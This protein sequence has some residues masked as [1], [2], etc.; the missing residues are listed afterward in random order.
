MVVIALASM[1][2]NYYISARPSINAAPPVCPQAA[3]RERPPVVMVVGNKTDRPY[4]EREVTSE[5]GRKL[6]LVRGDA[7][8]MQ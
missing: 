7:H 5:Q 1:P 3:L 4:E 8:W 2:Y 6:A